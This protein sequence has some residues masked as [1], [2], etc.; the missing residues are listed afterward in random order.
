MKD[1]FGDDVLVVDSNAI[2]IDEGD[3][4]SRATAFVVYRILSLLSMRDLCNVQQVSHF[5]YLLGNENEIWKL[6]VMRDSFSWESCSKGMVNTLRGSTLPVKWKKIAREECGQ[7]QCWKCKKKFQKCRN[8]AIACMYHPQGRELIEDKI[9]APS[10][11]YWTCCLNR[12]KVSPGC[13]IGYHSEYEWVK[14]GKQAR[15]RGD[16]GPLIERVAVEGRGRGGARV[17]L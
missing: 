8:S 4:I 9:G 17:S 7:Q 12:S 13:V 16:G 1:S 14:E 15:G 2:V 5:W 11:V 6:I 10:G 3:Q